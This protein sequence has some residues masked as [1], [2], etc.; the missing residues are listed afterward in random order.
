MFALIGMGAALLGLAALLRACR[1]AGHDLPRRTALLISAVTLLP[2]LALAS[3]QMFAPAGRPHGPTTAARVFF[4]NPGAPLAPGDW[5]PE[6]HANGWLHG[7]LPRLGGDGARLL[8]LDV[9]A[10][11]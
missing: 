3:W 6:L 1:G 2:P 7:E 10:H 8:V 5:L 9:W 4:P 11:W